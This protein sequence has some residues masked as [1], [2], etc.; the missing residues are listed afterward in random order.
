MDYCNLESLMAFRLFSQTYDPTDFSPEARA[1]AISQL[2]VIGLVI[3]A[4]LILALRWKSTQ[5]VQSIVIEGA[6]AIRPEEVMAMA[7]LT[8]ADTT[9]SASSSRLA[10]IR[11]N[12]LKHLPWFISQFSDRGEVSNGPIAWAGSTNCHLTLTSNHING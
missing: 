12:I 10:H 7:S 8:L 3:I 5:N 4:I 11:M 2:I 6:K 1:G 9:E